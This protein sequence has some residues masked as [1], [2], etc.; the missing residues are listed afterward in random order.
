[1]NPTNNPETFQEVINRIYRE[2]ASPVREPLIIA[3]NTFA[4]LHAGAEQFKIANAKEKTILKKFRD[5]ERTR[6]LN[7][8]YKDLLEAYSLDKNKLKDADEKFKELENAYNQL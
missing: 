5:E 2:Y 8:V 4:T 1:M 3:I 7:D 6:E